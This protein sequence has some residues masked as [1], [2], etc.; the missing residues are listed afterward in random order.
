MGAPQGR[1][2][3]PVLQLLGVDLRPP[4]GRSRLGAMTKTTSLALALFALLSL[5]GCSTYYTERHSTSAS[6]LLTPAEDAYW[7]DRR[8]R[9]DKAE[10]WREDNRRASATRMAREFP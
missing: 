3:G 7:I 2:L 9:E 1:L 4:G 10:E 6:R 8:W 5:G